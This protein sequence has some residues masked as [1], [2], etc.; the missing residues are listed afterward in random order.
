MV[1]RGGCVYMKYKWWGITIFV[2]LSLIALERIYI[3]IFNNVIYPFSYYRIEDMNIWDDK[4][5]TL[6]LIRNSDNTVKLKNIL[7]YYSENESEILII[8]LD[9]YYIFLNEDLVYV[10]TYE[11]AY[12]QKFWTNNYT[13]ERGKS[14]ILKY[15]RNKWK[16]EFRRNSN[17]ELKSEEILEELKYIP[18]RYD[19]ALIDITK[20]KL[21][22]YPVNMKIQ[23][24]YLFLYSAVNIELINLKK[25]I[26][27]TI[28]DKNFIFSERDIVMNFSEFVEAIKYSIGREFKIVKP[29]TIYTN[30]SVHDIND[31][32]L[33]SYVIYE[34]YVDSFNIFKKRH[35]K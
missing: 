17:Q 25:K 13:A 28:E 7:N 15:L 22:S 3:G 12:C 5:S 27:Y 16:E 2:M 35:G 29:A 11:G 21:F 18:F 9:G 23:G 14:L 8:T 24:N 33:A 34:F 6:V 4:N 26:K 10:E 20:H 32:P 19:G 1:Y 31:I 30:I